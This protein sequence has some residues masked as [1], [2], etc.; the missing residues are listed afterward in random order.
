MTRDKGKKEEKKGG[1][2]NHIF[3]NDNYSKKSMLKRTRSRMKI[4]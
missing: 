1:K 2:K 3:N 4:R